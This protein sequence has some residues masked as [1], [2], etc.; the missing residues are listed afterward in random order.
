V[1]AVVTFLY[2][3]WFAIGLLR[4]G[5]LPV[6]GTVLLLSVILQVC[7]GIA[8]VIFGLPLAVA[9]AHNAVGAG[10]VLTLVTVVH[11]LW[12]PG[13]PPLDN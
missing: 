7:L 1:G 12:M 11:R 10:L 8:N 6:L 9:V 5:V 13:V 2:I 3:A 4:G